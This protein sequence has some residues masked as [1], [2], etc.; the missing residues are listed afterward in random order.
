MFRED[1]IIILVGAGCSAEACIPTTKAM[2]D[3]LEG[4][5]KCHDWKEYSKFYDFIKSACQYADGIKGKFEENFDIERLINVISE[6]EKKENSILYPFIGSWNPR[7]LEIAGYDFDIIVKFKQKILQ[8]LK[9]W[10]SLEHYKSADYYRRFFDFQSEYNYSLRVFS[11]NYD[12][13]LEKNRPEDRE[14]ERGFDTDTRTWDWKRFEPREEYQ[15]AIYLY[16]LHG[17]ID[18]KRELEKGGILKEVDNIPEVPDLIF[19]T[20]YK[21]Q[22]I[23]PYL[24]SL[25]ELRK[26]SLMSRIILSIGYSFRDEH[27]NGI[28][29]QALQNRPDA[30]MIAVSPNPDKILTKLPRTKDQVITVPSAAREFLSE[31]SVNKLGELLNKS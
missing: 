11:L 27:I 28:L 15:P 16:K 6:L 26:Y 24:F 22:Y 19:G 29:E 3:K 10:V 25:Y 21:M 1:E 8:E 7:L 5:L 12:L 13:C 20:D 18:W 23:D 14:L 30:R 17:S 2:I 31:L 4:L 9:K